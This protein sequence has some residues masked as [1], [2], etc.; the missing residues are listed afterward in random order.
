MQRLAELPP[1][2]CWLRDALSGDN[3]LI[4][5]GSL[6]KL[7]GARCSKCSAEMAC[8]FNWLNDFISLPTPVG[9]HD[10]S[11]KWKRGGVGTGWAELTLQEGGKQPLPRC[12]FCPLLL[13]H[14]TRRGRFGNSWKSC[15]FQEGIRKG[16]IS[17]KFL[18]F[19]LLCLP[20]PH[21]PSSRLCTNKGNQPCTKCSQKGQYKNNWFSCLSLA[22]AVI[23]GCCLQLLCRYI[24]FRQMRLLLLLFGFDPLKA[25]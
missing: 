18:A 22:V 17:E 10:F 4:V 1:P 7:P 20:L 5:C 13:R 14:C 24:F 6:M 23:S 9:L 15:Q 11:S 3:G 12:R 16:K 2:A 19:S 25:S 21:L 8:D